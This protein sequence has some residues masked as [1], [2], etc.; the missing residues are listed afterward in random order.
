MEKTYEIAVI[1]GDGTGPEVVA[2]G[3]K[4]LETV[5]AKCNFGYHFS[6]YDMGGEHYLKTGET[7]SD[8]QL[9]SL[10]QKDAIYLGAIGHPEVKPG[11]L[12][13]GILLKTR[14]SLDQYINLRPVKLYEGVYTPI[15]DKLPEHVDFVVVRENTE[16]LYSGA[17]GCLKRGTPDEVATQ[18]SINTRKGVERCIRF[19]FEYCKK[20]NRAKKLT[21]CGKTNVLTY[22]F[23]LWERTFNEVANA[24]PDIDA[25]YAH[26]DA[27]CMWMVKNPEW[28][29]V[30]VTDN[31]FGDVITDLGAM[32]Q[33]GMGIAAGANINPDGVSM[34]EPIGG[35]APKYT[36]QQKI[37]PI[38][39]ILAA[40]LM[41]ETIGENEAASFIEAAVAKVLREN[42]KDVAAGKMGHTTQEV[43]DLIVAY[44]EANC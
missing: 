24:Y 20:R 1:P 35:S 2:E 8:Q 14:F 43:G 17:G 38:A 32:V 3:L 39:A 6:T 33:G 34:F 36:G 21:L 27:L 10:G 4:V 41:L 26:V 22:A 11:I 42:I 44:I 40:Q 23:D 25:D 15:K 13:K 12:E 9:E 5:A 7:I 19:A 18:E 29:D 31:M 28:F 37:N 30:I 16:G